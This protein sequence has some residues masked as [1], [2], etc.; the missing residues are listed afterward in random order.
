M[1]TA[2]MQDKEIATE[3][4][5]FTWQ[6]IKALA[7]KMNVPF[8][9]RNDYQRYGYG[10]QANRH[11]LSKIEIVGY[12]DS[13][14]KNQHDT[15]VINRLGWKCFVQTLELYFLKNGIK[16]ELVVPEINPRTGFRDKN[17]IHI[18]K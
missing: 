17:Y 6:A 2:T 9:A 3:Y 8:Y 5:E 11:D 7:T 13:S 10:F 15:D 14:G 18:Y 16:Y 12:V 1:T 4:Q